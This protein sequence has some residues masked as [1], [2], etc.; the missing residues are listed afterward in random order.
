MLP[1][2]CDTLLPS[3]KQGSGIIGAAVAV[4]ANIVVAVVAVLANIIVAAVA[5]LAN[6]IVAAV[7]ACQYCCCHR[8]FCRRCCYCRAGERRDGSCAAGEEVR[9]EDKG[10]KAGVGYARR[11]GGQVPCEWLCVLFA[12]AVLPAPLFPCTRTRDTHALTQ[13]QHMS[14]SS[15]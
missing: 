12:I 4:L 5:V 13:M 15:L 7:A 3:W 10:F 8:R 2:L 6:I 1:A 9:E 14:T 11:V